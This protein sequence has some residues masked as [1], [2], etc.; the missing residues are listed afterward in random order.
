MPFFALRRIA[1]FTG[2]I[3]L[4]GTAAAHAATEPAGFV[5][6]A[7]DSIWNLPLR[8]DAPIAANSAG[9]VSYLTQSVH[10]AGI[11]VEGGAARQA[12]AAQLQ[13]HA[14]IRR[15][16]GSRAISRCTAHRSP[17]PR[18]RTPHGP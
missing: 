17:R 13:H 6:F 9:Y 2:I 12:F 10:T 15:L 4:L 1:T 5:P 7:P 8:D 11:D 18:E 16:C 14:A 3:V